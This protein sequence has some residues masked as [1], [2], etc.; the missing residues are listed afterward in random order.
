MELTDTV[1]TIA[2]EKKE[3]AKGKY[4]VASFDFEIAQTESIEEYRQFCQDL[5]VFSRDT[6]TQTAEMGLCSNSY[7][8]AVLPNLEVQALLN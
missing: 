4:S 8:V 1:L 6:I 2:S 7:P 5:Q 3:N